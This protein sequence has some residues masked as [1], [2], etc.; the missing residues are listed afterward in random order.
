MVSCIPSYHIFADTIKSLPE[1]IRLLLL[2]LRIKQQIVE[3]HNHSLI[4]IEQLL[5]SSN[6]LV[7]INSAIII[8]S[9]KIKN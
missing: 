1:I 3:L 5:G 7:A 9:Q 8:T 2:P 4:P 6:N